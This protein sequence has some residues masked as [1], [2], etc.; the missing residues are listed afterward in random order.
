MNPRNNKANNKKKRVIL[1]IGCGR[2]KVPGAIGID[3]A[4]NT[5]ADIN[6]DLNTQSLPF[7]DNSV[8]FVHSS[9]SLEHLSLE[10]FFN[11]I[12]EIYRVL[13]PS[14]Q[15][16][17]LAPYYQSAANLGNP[18]H[19]NQVCF[20]EHTFRFFSS[21]T[22][23]AAM[24]PEDYAT[25]SCPFWGLR[26][27]AH[28]EINV[29]FDLKAV[30]Y[31]YFPKYENLGSAELR[32]ARSSKFSVVDQIAYHLSPLKPLPLRPEIAPQTDLTN[33]N[34]HVTQQYSYFKQQLNWCKVNIPNFFLDPPLPIESKLLEGRRILLE[35][36]SSFVSDSEGLFLQGDLLVPAAVV[37]WSLD[38]EIQAVQLVVDY[39]V[40]KND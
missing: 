22:T 34:E 20:N 33:A 10:G 40:K 37:I 18:F 23:T 1:D 8:D 24:P 29:E 16:F 11:V 4:R 36:L 2:N 14:G 31:F 15:L 19:N 35:G 13:K 12:Y 5:D 21:S 28:K 6:L 26:Y 7:E 9:H 27:S 30:R 3:I 38:R 39:F 32:A 17:L 25:P